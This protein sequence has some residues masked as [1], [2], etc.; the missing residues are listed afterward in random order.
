MMAV[1]PPGGPPDA[2]PFC[3]PDPALVLWSS[4][5]YHVL[6]DAFPR[7]A[8]HILVTTRGHYA[9]H[10]HAPAQWLEDLAAA[11]AQARRF[12]IEVFGAASF[13]EN[14]G[15][16]QEVP[17]AHL[18]GVPFAATVPEAWLAEGMLRRVPGWPAVR[19]EVER[20]GAYV[21]IETS[22]GC[23]LLQRDADY[24]RLLYALRRQIVDQTPAEFDP[25]AG[26]LLRGGPGMVEQ[27]VGLWRTWAAGTQA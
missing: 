8:G 15:R 16:R 5:H 18:H 17:H 9:S 24:G 11:Q 10:M 7:T 3:V 1:T 22:D 19:A 21:F 13:L 14:G 26:Q 12:L 20:A 25:S 4:D 27:T 6:A 23:Y 2:C